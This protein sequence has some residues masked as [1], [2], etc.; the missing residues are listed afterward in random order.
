[1]SL[2][3]GHTA[4]RTRDLSQEVPTVPLHTT[5]GKLFTC[6][7]V[8]QQYNMVLAKVPAGKVTVGLASGA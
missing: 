6:A 1:M 5:L 8:T 4:I 2:C 3:G 7:S